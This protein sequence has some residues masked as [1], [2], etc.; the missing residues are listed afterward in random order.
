MHTT[1]EEGMQATDSSANGSTDHGSSPD[2]DRIGPEGTLGKM[3]ARSIGEEASLSVM[4]GNI[5][6][7]VAFD[8]RAQRDDELYDSW[9]FHKFVVFNTMIAHPGLYW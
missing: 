2:E 7:Q 8:Y 6:D 1:D 3:E 4:E 5:V 9:H